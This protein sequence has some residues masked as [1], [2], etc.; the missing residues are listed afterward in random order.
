M[1]GR[2][3][4]SPARSTG[5]IK[6]LVNRRGGVTRCGTRLWAE[7]QGEQ[8]CLQRPRSRREG[9]GGTLAA[10]TYGLKTKPPA[11]VVPDWRS[12]RNGSQ[13]G[14]VCQSAAPEAPPSRSNLLAASPVGGNTAS[15][16][17]CQSA[18]RRFRN[19]AASVT[20]GNRCKWRAVVIGPS[21][22]VR[23]GA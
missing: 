1:T 6:K 3:G 19:R 8:W 7:R 23:R 13:C 15:G 14:R 10:A 4:T 16:Q 5:V 2:L 17:Q 11:G 22:R 12:L 18:G 20:H 21:N 9:A